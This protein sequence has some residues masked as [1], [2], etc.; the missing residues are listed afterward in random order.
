MPRLDLKSKSQPEIDHR[1][2]ILS[3]RWLLVILASYLTVFGYIGTALFPLAATASLAF[4]FTNVLLVLIPRGRFI[5]NNIQRAISILDV[6]FVSATLY[7]LRQPENYLYAAFIAIFMLAAIWRDLRLVLFSL[8]TVSL[9]YGT[10]VYFRLFRFEFDVNLERFLTLALF[11]VVSMFY[12]FLSERLTQ[13]AKLSNSMIEENRVAEAMVE[14][15]RILS[16]S[17]NTDKVLSSFVSLLREVIGAEECSIVQVDSKS[18]VARLLMRATK[19]EERN[20]AIDLDQ[21]PELKQAYASRHLLFAPDAKPTGL[22]AIPMVMNESALGLIVVYS[23]RL[24]PIMTEANARFFE[25]MASTAANALHNAQ[26]YEEVEQRART[27]FLTGL[28]NQRDFQATLSLELSR[29]HRHNRTLSLL[30]ID[31]D[32]LKEVNDR[33]G[34]PTGDAV[35]KKIADTIRRTCRETDFPAR[36]GGEEFAVILPETPLSGGIEVAERLRRNIAAEDFSEIGQVTASIGVSAYPVNALTKVDLIRAAD[37]AL[38]NAKN[39]G[40][41][42]VAYFEAQLVMR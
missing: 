13:D 2:A 12:V 14:M 32:F 17:L 19:P 28:P 41:D 40:R 35:I 10:F 11:F 26:L 39:G 27:D 4:A 42:R 22:I 30:M 34:H 37:Q 23:N 36:Y 38:Y 21:C 5:E 18:G 9:L 3:L 6:I 15:T 33:F 25:V 31:L 20:V 24:R 8:L 1:R 7:L 29:A 16:S